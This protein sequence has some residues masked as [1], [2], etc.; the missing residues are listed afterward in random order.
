MELEDMKL[1]GEID[2]LMSDLGVYNVSRTAA[3]VLLL[4]S[5]IIAVSPEG[6]L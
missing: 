5:G 6:P 3:I 1:K 4:T 2:L